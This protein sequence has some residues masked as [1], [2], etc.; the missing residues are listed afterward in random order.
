MKTFDF[1]LSF[2]IRIAY[3]LIHMW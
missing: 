3:T 1:V 2:V